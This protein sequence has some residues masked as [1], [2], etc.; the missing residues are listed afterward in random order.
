VAREFARVNSDV[1]LENDSVGA[2][3]IVAWKY[4]MGEGASALFNGI[5][6]EV[7]PS[8]VTLPTIVEGQPVSAMLAAVMPFLMTEQAMA[9]KP[10]AQA[11][12]AALS[13]VSFASDKTL[14]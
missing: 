8:I 12:N 4:R 10:D 6:K 11:M 14:E 3:C 13:K 7:D 5:E 1:H 9:G 2:R